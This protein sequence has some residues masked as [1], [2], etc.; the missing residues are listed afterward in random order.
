MRTQSVVTPGDKLSQTIFRLF[1][2]W[3]SCVNLFS[4][5]LDQRRVS[6]V[7]PCQFAPYWLVH[8]AR[9]MRRC[10]FADAV[11][12]V[13]SFTLWQN[14]KRSCTGST[15]VINT[16]CKSI[17]CRMLAYCAYIDR[18]SYRIE[19][20]LMM[21]NQW[22]TFL[23]SFI[24]KLIWLPR[25]ASAIYFLYEISIS[26]YHKSSEIWCGYL[27]CCKSIIKD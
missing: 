14:E 4:T 18:F 6:A 17:S 22:G 7:I 25:L 9:N 8:N 15:K 11:P 10:F 1:H 23:L 13:M 26:A 5:R 16:V 24:Y 19:K 21:S 12:G 27:L 20:K 3:K 2:L